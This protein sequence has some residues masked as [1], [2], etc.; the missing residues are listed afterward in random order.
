MERRDFLK[1]SGFTLTALLLSPWSIYAFP[2]REG[3][4]LIPFADQ[5][6]AS[7]NKRVLLDWN[8]LDT[9][10][11]PNEK[12]LQRLAL[13]ETRSSPGCVEIRSERFG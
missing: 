4:V 7:E 13:R 12:F 2:R 10:I 8:H 3:E 5:P 9:F 1:Q 11:T 6:P